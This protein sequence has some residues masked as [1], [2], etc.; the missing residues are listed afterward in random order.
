LGGTGL[1]VSTEKHPIASAA[2][3]TYGRG[4]SFGSRWKSFVR[5]N[6]GRWVAA[7]L[8]NTS[9]PYENTYL[10]LDP[11]VHDPLGDPVCRVTSGPKPN[12]SR[13]MAY[14]QEKMEEWFRAAGAIEV[15]K[16]PSTGPILSTHAFGGTRMGD[17][18][19][20]NVVDRWGFSHEVP[21]LAIVGGS[22]IGTSGAR[23]PTLTI[24]ALAWRTADYLIKNWKS[25]GA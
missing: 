1:H 7:Y 11:G 10:D 12:E 3:G 24:Q 16:T 17:D 19:E 22:V 6:A 25:I 14:G 9:F 4:P 20:T 23:N 15:I 2:M 21:N 13:S 18:P 5:E 8:Q